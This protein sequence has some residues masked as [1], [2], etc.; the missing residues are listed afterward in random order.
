VITN[1]VS[2]LLLAPFCKIIPGDYGGL[3]SNGFGDVEEATSI[4][5]AAS[6]LFDAK[7]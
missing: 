4:F 6:G 2:D 3:Q 1:Y 5:D 7:N